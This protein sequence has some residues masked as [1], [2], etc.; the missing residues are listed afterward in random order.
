M[1]ILTDA[2]AVIADEEH[3]T[4]GRSA[5][6]AH[7]VLVSPQSDK[8]RRWCMSGAMIKAGT[9]GDDSS[10]WGALKR[11][12]AG[13]VPIFNDTHTHEEVLAAF[14]RAIAEEQKS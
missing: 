11:Q 9:T 2:R 13:V 6:D 12:C 4:Q 1:S 10:E 7:G 14:D 3:W 5:R 8:A